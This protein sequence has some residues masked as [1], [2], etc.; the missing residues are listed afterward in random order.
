[1]VRLSELKS[2]A[3]NPRPTRPTA[4]LQDSIITQ[5]EEA[6]SATEEEEEEAAELGAEAAEESRP[7]RRRP[8]RP[9]EPEERVRGKSVSASSTST[10]SA[11][12]GL[13]IFGE[14]NSESSKKKKNLA[15]VLHPE[16]FT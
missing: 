9:L 10:Y 8:A 5:R 1:M 15:I 14:K 11:K 13:K 2:T 12:Q 16:R 6:Q 7:R 4:A 3:Q